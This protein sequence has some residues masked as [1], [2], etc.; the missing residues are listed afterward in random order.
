MRSS[1]RRGNIALMLSIP[2][3][4]GERSSS[5]GNDNEALRDEGF[6]GPLEPHKSLAYSS[7]RL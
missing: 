7:A 4:V 3:G 6:T 5:G 1:L 2:P